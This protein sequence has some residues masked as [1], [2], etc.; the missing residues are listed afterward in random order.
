[1]L[2][3]VRVLSPSRVAG[4]TMKSEVAR[5]VSDEQRFRSLFRAHYQAIFFYAARRSAAT[6]VDPDDVV[7]ET[8][9]V[10]WRRR[11]ACPQGR[12]L[13]WLYGIAARVLANQR[14]SQRRALRLHE[15][16]Q[17][18]PRVR[19]VSA[20]DEAAARAELGSLAA[21]FAGLRESDAE[22]LRLAAWEGL[23]SSETAVVLGCS[24]NAAAIRLHRARKRLE[25]AV[26]K[27]SRGTGHRES[28]NA[29][30]A[31]NGG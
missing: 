24:E 22:L 16:L 23:S 17:R 6:G 7:A 8:F 30:P 2:E 25:E 28:A 1:M 19:Q 13:P 21:A 9:A 29:E 5:S 26:L 12:E 31:E 14:R 27:E 4:R 10:A 3:E 20:E 18:F 11:E 15:R